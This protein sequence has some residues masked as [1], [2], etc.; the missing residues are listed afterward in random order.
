MD[1]KFGYGHWYRQD[2]FF[3]VGG[4]VQAANFFSIEH[5]N[6]VEEEKLMMT[7]HFFKIWAGKG[8]PV[9]IKT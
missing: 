7:H 5:D 8:S 3:G 4:W 2:G 1:R 6:D 9:F